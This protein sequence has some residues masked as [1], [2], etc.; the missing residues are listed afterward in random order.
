MKTPGIFYS[1]KG[2][3]Y[4]C[5]VD[6]CPKCN[7]SMRVAYTSKYKTVQGMAEVSMIAQRTKRCANLACE[8]GP[9]ILGSAEWRQ[10][11]PVSCTYGYDVIAQIGW[12]RQ[13]LQQ[14]FATIRTD[15]RERLRISET[16]VR[17]LYHYRYLPLLACHEREQLKQLEIVANQMG[18]LISLDGLA[19]EAG[20]A[21]L[22]LVRELVSG[23]TLRCGWMSRQDQAAFVAFLRPIADLGLRVSAV[24]SDKQSGLLPA[25]AEVF[26]QAKHAYCQ[27]HYLRNIAVPVVE[28]DE[29][30]KLLLRQD[31][32]AAI[33]QYI[34]QAD[35]ETEG[36][37]TITGVLPSPVAAKSPVSEPVLPKQ[38][39]PLRDAITRE[40]CRRIRY[41]L[42]LKGRPPFRLAGMEMFVSLSEVKQ[43][44]D[45]LM[46]HHPTP[47]LLKLQQELQKALHS[48]QATYSLIR[49]AADWLEHIAAL[50][51]PQ[52]IPHRS[53]DQIRQDLFTY[54]TKIHS[55]RCNDPL[56]RN[57]FRIILKTTRSYAPGLFHC[58]DVPGLPRTN[59]DRESD[60]RDLG[61]R[62]L[63]TTGQKGLT[64]RTIQRQGAWELLSH[65]N[66]LHETIR[67]VSQIVPYK[68]QDERLRIRQHRNR[69][70]LHTR[71]PLLAN[72]QLAHLEHIWNSIPENSP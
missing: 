67:V 40:F 30:M 32:R 7:G 1:G 15:L 43:C 5:E 34:S 46:L 54:L 70:R 68:F 13:N 57:S 16:Q 47:V 14:S 69:F 45:R 50:L 8:A 53:G 27:S 41:L 2:T 11:A 17:G 9:M 64:L 18:L 60:F 56:L 63:R 4:D 58:Y 33:G 21:Q 26:P 6:R 29:A 36:I 71:S 62:L 66:T 19:P 24:M 23:I 39:E 37:L 52:P 72:R 49:E 59:N 28:A 31:V 61:R 42:T 3:I 48:A 35:V 51:D 65:P 38:P 12:Q 44:L 10:I 55:N 22:W 20:E 25:V